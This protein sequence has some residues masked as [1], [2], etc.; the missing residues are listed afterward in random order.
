[1]Y[2]LYEVNEGIAKLVTLMVEGYFEQSYEI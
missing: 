1:M 2:I